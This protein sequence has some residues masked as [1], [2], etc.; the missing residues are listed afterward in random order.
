MASVLLG[1]L[2]RSS[3]LATYGRGISLGGVGGDT[4]AIVL[5]EAVFGQLCVVL[6]CEARVFGGRF[7]VLGDVLADAEAGFG[8]FLDYVP[9]MRLFF[10]FMA[11]VFDTKFLFFASLRFEAIFFLAPFGS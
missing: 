7:G 4:P 3:G 8:I 9:I 2:G 11:L 1:T 5:L 10:H 6:R